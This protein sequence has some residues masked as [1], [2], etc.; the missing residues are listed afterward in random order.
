[1]GTGGQHGGPPC[2]SEIGQKALGAMS[3]I[4]ESDKKEYLA[5]LD[6]LRDFENQRGVETI[7]LSTCGVRTY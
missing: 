3:P 7:M 6:T 2:W 1:M 4:E 5:Y